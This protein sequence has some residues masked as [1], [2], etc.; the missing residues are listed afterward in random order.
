[1]NYIPIFKI[2]LLSPEKIIKWS[3]RQ[4]NK[5][6]IKGE[7][8]EPLTINF[9]KGFYEKNGLFWEKI[10]GPLNSWKWNCGLYNKNYLYQIVPGTIWYKCGY[11][12]NDSRIRRYRMGYILLKTPIIHIWYLK[13]FGQILSNL[14]NISTIQLERFIYYKDFFIKK[15][16]LIYKKSLNKLLIKNKFFNYSYLIFSSYLIQIILKNL[17]ILFELNKWRELL[18]YK[19]NNEELKHLSKKAR[20]LHLF[21]IS[22]IKPE[23][24][25]LNL[26]P[27]I[28][29]NLRPFYKLNDSNLFIMSSINNIYRK[30]IIRNNRLNRWIILRKSLPI[31]FEIFEKRMLQESIDELLDHTLM[32][33]K[34]KN[35]PNLSLSTILKGKYGRFRQNLLGKRVDFSGRSV[36]ISGSDLTFNKIGLPFDLALNLLT[37][38]LLNIFQLNNSI[39][40]IL[41][42][43]NLLE[44][45]TIIIKQILKNILNKKVVLLNRAPTLHRMNIQGFKPYLIE[46]N[47]LKLFPL[48]C[49]SFN[50]DFD[51]DQ[52]GIFLPIS[53]TSQY[54]VKTKMVFDKNLI[55][56]TTNKSI[57]KLSQNI[58]LGIYTLINNFN[59]ILNSNIFLSDNNDLIYT[60]FNKLI[61]L[62]DLIWIK[63]KF[64]K[65][66]NYELTNFI[67]TNLGKIFLNK[68]LNF[69]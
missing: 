53:K 14:L 22:N 39:K 55:S 2:C 57:F 34:I 43:S 23:W 38:I 50:A 18:V 59:L 7:I 13:G 40:T 9:K 52:M 16:Y 37:P 26:L 58:I 21:F 32:K 67:L 66:K 12:L 5:I 28:P 60:Y 8:T 6:F 20:I 36:I 54:E 63:F 30:I 69:K 4:V 25:C 61:T 45:K 68:L 3:T 19:K 47:S 11:E 51:G 1:M 15:N 42:S 41:K 17:N 27:I 44:Y 31:L 64:T 24:I 65:N 56:P 49:S 10:F 46:N 29:P 48:A 35:R 62:K 33:T